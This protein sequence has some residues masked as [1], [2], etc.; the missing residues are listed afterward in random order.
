MLQTRFSPVI[1][2]E[3]DTSEQASLHAR[4]AR[5]FD[6]REQGE[7]TRAGVESFIH[8]CFADIHGAHV[9]HFMP[10]LLSLHASR[11]E[12]VAAFGLREARSSRLFLETYL[13]RPIEAVLQARLGQPVQRDEIM[14]V[15]NLSARYPGAA[16]WLS[17]AVTA[18]LHESGYR[19]VVFTGTTALRNGFQRLGL[20]PIELAAASVERLP[21]NERADWGRYYESNPVVMAGDVA[22]GYHALLSQHELL[23]T[24]RASMTSVNEA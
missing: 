21:P 15:G 13:N 20:R 22:N 7:A 19:W 14:E 16:R 8:D 1:H 24:L 2:A 5:L 6:L 4:L 10:R 9:S 11:G 17:V 18:M 23:H 3:R 12:I